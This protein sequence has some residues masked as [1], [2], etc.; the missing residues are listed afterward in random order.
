MRTGVRASGGMASI[1]R[2]S[3]VR[4]TIDHDLQP[5][6]TCALPFRGHYH[7][8]THKSFHLIPPGRPGQRVLHDFSDLD[9][10]RRRHAGDEARDRPCMCADFQ[11]L[12]SARR[13]GDIDNSGSGRRRSATCRLQRLR[14]TEPSCR[15][16]LRRADQR[17]IA[18]R[19]PGRRT[20][21]RR[22]APP[23]PTA[24]PATSDGAE[25]SFQN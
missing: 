13:F 12:T 9:D 16:S 25:Q 17:Q 5:P 7:G 23:K 11:E 6:F 10:A 19:V 18:T 22:S 24:S 1:A 8:V 21:G 2:A 4:E 3:A 15:D 20:I 14:L